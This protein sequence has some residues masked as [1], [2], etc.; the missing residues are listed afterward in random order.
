[1]SIA[2]L[3]LVVAAYV[4]LRVSQR[5]QAGEMYTRISRLEG[6]LD[7]LSARGTPTA[8]DHLVDDVERL[9]ERVD[10]LEQLLAERPKRD[11]LPGGE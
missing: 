5:G 10:F 3:V 11:R 6:R 1:M 8:D 7:E 2:T 4:A 9:E